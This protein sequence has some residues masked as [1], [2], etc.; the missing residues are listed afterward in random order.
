ML[1][2]SRKVDEGIQIGDDI[3]VVVLA[4]KG[5]KVRLGINA[6]RELRVLRGE[7]AGESMSTSVKTGDGMLVLSRRVSQAIQIGDCV[8]VTVV[9][10]SGKR[11]SLGIDA[12][13]DIRILRSELRDTDAA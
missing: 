5:N 11:I 12:P 10:I 7:L 8:T 13:S 4:C 1:V 6:P 9:K 3:S 2:L